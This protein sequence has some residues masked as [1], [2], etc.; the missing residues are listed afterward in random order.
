MSTYPM[1]P[2]HTTIRLK[3]FSPTWIGPNPYQEGFISGSRDGVIA[4]LD[5]QGKDFAE[6]REIS[7]SQSAINGIDGINKFLA[8]TTPQEITVDRKS[9]RLNSSHRCIS[10]AV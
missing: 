3:D 1:P 4:F 9:T 5:E 7:P 10:Y 6:R 2:R 8:V